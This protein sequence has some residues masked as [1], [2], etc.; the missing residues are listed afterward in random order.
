MAKAAAIP[1]HDKSAG[2]MRTVGITYSYRDEQF[3][4]VLVAEMPF[5]NR[6]ARSLSHN[7]DVASDL[8]QQTALLAWQARQHYRTGGKIRAWLTVILRNEYFSTRRRSW[9]SVYLDADRAASLESPYQQQA[10][11]ELSDAVRAIQSLP[12]IQQ[13]DLV[14]IAIGGATYREA[15]EASNSPVGT[16]KCRVARARAAVRKMCEET[17]PRPSCFRPAIGRAAATLLELERR[18]EAN[19]LM[20]ELDMAIESRRAP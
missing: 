17:Q 2:A 14:R 6:L 3:A 19:T 1:V 9:R 13:R 5:L 11:A 16:V 7:S 4:E 8:A 15:A 20:G 18:F 10:A 12:D